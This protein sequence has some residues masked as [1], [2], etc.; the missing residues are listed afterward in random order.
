MYTNGVS[1]QL[2]YSLQQRT[3]NVYVTNSA[4]NWTDTGMLQILLLGTLVV[5]VVVGEVV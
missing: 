5:V 1:L 4:K 2:V 3:V